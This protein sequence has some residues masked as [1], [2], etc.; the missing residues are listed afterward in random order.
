MNLKVT[1]SDLEG[2]ARQLGRAAEDAVAFKNH[3]GRHTTV[4]ASNEGLI[5]LV[6]TTH[7]A[8]VQQ[9]N[10]AFDKLQSILKAADGELGRSATY[11][12]KTDRSVA[13]KA[14]ATYPL[15]KR[16]K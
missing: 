2:Y 13:A 9:V 5:N 1:P 6:L 14:D 8:T 12:I 16:P 15:V 7:T 4:G 11:Y 10:S 3:C